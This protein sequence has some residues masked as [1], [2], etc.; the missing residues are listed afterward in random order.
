[1]R[2]FRANIR[3][4]AIIYEGIGRRHRTPGFQHRQPRYQTRFVIGP[5]LSPAAAGL[6]GSFAG[7]MAARVLAKFGDTGAGPGGFGHF[8]QVG[9]PSWA[10]FRFSGSRLASCSICFGVISF[11]KSRLARGF[12][13]TL[14]LAMLRCPDRCCAGDAHGGRWRVSRSAAAPE[15][16]WVLPDPERA[17]SKRHCV[18]AFRRAAG[19]SPICSTNGTFLN[20]ESEPIGRGKSRELRNGD[21]LSFGAYEIEVHIEEEGAGAARGP[22]RR[23]RSR[24]HRPRR[25]RIVR[26]RSVRRRLRAGREGGSVTR[27]AARGRGRARPLRGAAGAG[28]G[29]LPADFD[30]LAPDTAEPRIPR[31]DPVGSL[32]RISRTPSRRRCRAVLP[33]DWDRENRCLRGARDP[34]AANRR[35]S[36]A[37]ACRQ[38]TPA[39]APVPASDPAPRFTRG[40]AVS[41]GVTAPPRMPPAPIAP[42]RSKAP[43]AAASDDLLAAFLRG[44][45][46]PDAILRTPTG[47]DGRRSARRSAPSSQGCARR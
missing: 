12:G 29:R 32:L 11:D 46:L 42:G 33:D 4:A 17:L 41:S 35:R 37:S 20:R 40:E 31:P 23:T 8:R 38:A 30:P 1:M 18:L 2:N 10:R 22:H 36:R 39:P 34:S 6:R 14:T 19:R 15:N 13:M 9:S 16:D 25:R 45:R 47:R 26:A 43:P 21:R 3:P 28:P 44:C 24:R 27:P 5:Y 7:V